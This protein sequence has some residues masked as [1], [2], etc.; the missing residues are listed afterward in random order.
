MLVKGVGHPQPA[1]HIKKQLQQ[2]VMRFVR[3]A[4]LV[5][6]DLERLAKLLQG[7]V[8]GVGTLTLKKGAA[9]G[10]LAAVPPLDKQVVDLG[11]CVF[12]AAFALAKPLAG[13]KK[14]AFAKAGAVHVP[15]T[16]GQIVRLID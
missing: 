3:F 12:Q 15:G 4:V 9:L 2:R 1:A 11:Q 8:K 7:A 14:G 5:Q 10:L 6:P 13:V 16:A